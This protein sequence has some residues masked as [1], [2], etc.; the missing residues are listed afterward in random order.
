MT[1]FFGTYNHRIDA[2]GRVALPAKFR[3]S[4]DRENVTGELV[5]TTSPSKYDDTHNESLYVF[6]LEDFNSWINS[7]FEVVGGYNPRKK[8][9]ELLMLALHANVE[10]VSIDS[11]GRIN[12]P[13]KFRD[14]AGLEADVSIVGNSG[15]FEVWD[16]KRM[17]QKLTEI[18]LESLLYD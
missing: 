7:F 9:H 5:V 10:D 13:Q 17:E 2:K 8:E 15:H 6:S 4:L 14:A 18:D 16:A 1:E 3:K 12:I 11:A